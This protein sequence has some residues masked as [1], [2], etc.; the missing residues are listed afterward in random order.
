[1]I[2]FGGIPLL[3]PDTTDQ[4]EGT[5]AHSQ[6]CDW[7]DQFQLLVDSGVF[8]ELKVVAPDSQR[9]RTRYDHP[10]GCGLPIPNWPSGP[11]PRLNQLWWPTGASRWARG[12]FLVAGSDISSSN[13]LSRPQALVMGDETT[14]RLLEAQM[15]ALPLRPLSGVPGELYVLPLVDARYWW[16]TMN[17]GAYQTI[18]P[19]DDTPLAWSELFDTLGGIVGT[20]E[21]DEIPSSY[22]YPDWVEFQ[23]WQGNVA[24]LIDALCASVGQRFTRGLDGTNFSDTADT[25]ESDYNDNRSGTWDLICG[26]DFQ[27]TATPANCRVSFTKYREHRPYTIGEVQSYSNSNPDQDVVGGT[28]KHIHSAAYADFGTGGGSPD[29][30]SILN[31]LASRISQ[32]YFAWLRR[33]YDITFAGMMDWIPTGYDDGTEYLW[34]TLGPN[35]E[36]LAQTRV[37]TLPIDFGVD[38]QLSQDPALEVYPRFLIGKMDAD[39]S[40]GASGVVSIWNTAPG[41]ETDSGNN[42]TKVYN[43]TSDNLVK[44]TLVW[45]FWHEWENV[46]YCFKASSSAALDIV[47]FRLTSSLSLGTSFPTTGSASAV[48]M[49]WDTGS[50]TYVDGTA[51]TVIDWFNVLGGPGEWQGQGDPDVAGQVGLYGYA[52][53]L[54]D[55]SEYQILYMQHQ[56]GFAEFTTTAPMAGGGA[57]GTFTNFWDGRTV[58][59]SFTIYDTLNYYNAAPAMTRF[60]VK[61]DN[62][63]GKYVIV[64]GPPG[65][66]PLQEALVYISNDFASGGSD[67]GAIIQTWGGAAWGPS[68]MPPIAI[69]DSANFGPGHQGSYAIVQFSTLSG[70]WEIVGLKGGGGTDVVRFQLTAPLNLGDGTCTAITMNWDTNTNQYVDGDPI[71]VHDSTITATY[72][73]TWQGVAGMRGFAIPLFGLV[74]DI[75]WMEEQGLFVEFTLDE[76]MTD[77]QASATFENPW[78][79]FGDGGV[80]LVSDPSGMFPNAKQYAKGIAI[81][82]AH[83]GIYVAVHIK[84][85]Q[86]G[87]TKLFK[88]QNDIFPQDFGGLATATVL[89]YNADEEAYDE[90]DETIQVHDPSHMLCAQEPMQG[91]ATLVNGR[92]EIQECGHVAN[93]ME[94]TANIDMKQDDDFCEN[95]TGYGFSDGQWSEH[96]TLIDNLIGLAQDMKVA[97]TRH[98]YTLKKD[99]QGSAV[100]K[101]GIAPW[102]DRVGFYYEIVEAECHPQKPADQTGAN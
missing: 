48:I 29:N 7:Q 45:C 60:I 39:T 59:G 16:Q 12:Y 86:E 57:T 95:V 21:H 75:V 90:T 44:N 19:R 84:I 68:G 70:R 22:Q 9:N 2:T 69:F 76:D 13:Q 81:W 92:Y 94:F 47:R 4:G 97:N 18:A 96:G 72:D 49:T 67:P 80:E 32:D 54:T 15:F 83:R 24:V 8:N 43:W 101:F 55:K 93:R 82:D 27:P 25:A 62:K 3:F 85:D 53:R 77:G 65:P 11:A 88:L 37:Q 28:E 79:G 6:L 20:I 102:A 64:Y 34:G 1:M 89:V 31:S 33:G 40:A 42:L 100:L 98:M 26:D 14:G 46:W 56:A 36:Q 73:G 17:W 71:I 74:Y 38:T 5:P 50:S 23:R 63:R 30:N 66:G 78:H 58:A 52:L 10:D 99:S 35:N 91:I 61:W 41:S 51:I 87:T